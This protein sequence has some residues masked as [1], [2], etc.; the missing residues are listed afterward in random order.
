[1]I[2]RDGHAPIKISTKA[3][4]QPCFTPNTDERKSQQKHKYSHALNPTATKENL[5]KSTST[6]TLCTQPQRKKIS[7]KAQVQ[8][9]FTPNTNK[10]KSQ[11]KHKYSHALNPT[12]TKENLNKST[13]TAMLYTQYQR[14][15]ISTKA[16][17]RPCFKPN[18]NKSANRCR[19]FTT[20]SYSTRTSTA[21]HYTQ[22]QLV[23]CCCFTPSQPVRSPLGGNTMTSK[24]Q[25]RF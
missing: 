9:C 1:M 2:Q 13:S 7:T 17:V 19:P 14:K 22:W 20:C 11:Q 5:N 25:N 24:A 15:K 3:Q 6:A 16:Q 18:T 21:V 10:R 23:S 8:P 12:P 4:V